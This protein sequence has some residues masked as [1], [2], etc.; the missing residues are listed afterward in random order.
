MAENKLMAPAGI[1]ITF[2]LSFSRGPLLRFVN[3]LGGAKQDTG[4]CVDKVEHYVR[5]ENTVDGANVDCVQD[6]R[7][8]WLGLPTHKP[9]CFG[10]VTSL[11][12]QSCAP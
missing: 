2:T 1:G 6:P 4:R 9:L 8:G 5:K 10:H 3:W 7:D 11:P 12:W